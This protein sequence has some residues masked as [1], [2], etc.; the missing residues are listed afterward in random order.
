MSHLFKYVTSDTGRKI[1]KNRT[2]R[3]STPPMLNDPFDMQFAFQLRID[4]QAARALAL[5]KLW[6]HVY[7]EL[8]DRPLNDLGREIRRCR[9]ELPRMSREEFSRDREFGDIV[10]TSID[11]TEERIAEFSQV[12]QSHFVNDKILC[13]SEMSESILMWSYYAQNHAGIVLRFTDET[14]DNPLVKA[15]PVR[16]VDQIP[17]LFD[18]EML[19]DMLA[20][21]EGMDERR[22][23]DEVVYTKSSHWAHEREWRVYSGRGRSDASYEDVPFNAKELDGVIFGVRTTEADRTTLAELIKTSYP[24]VALLQ[25][26]V[27]TDNY[28]LAIESTE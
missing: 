17:S 27:R 21:Y 18:D 10:D 23:M 9:D 12:I 25:A 20:G 13:L 11:D 15:R 26:R 4:R 16:Y 3:W 2:L 14:P 7:G 6:Q 8:L 28:E 22:I 24:H 5:G 19:S 1:I